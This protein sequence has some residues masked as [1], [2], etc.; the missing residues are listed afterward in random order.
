MAS[1]P[2]SNCWS[3][4]LTWLGV[5]AGLYLDTSWCGREGTGG[6]GP[7]QAEDRFVDLWREHSAAV[8]RYA[9]RR[10]PDAEVDEV[11][12]ETFL[13]AWRRLQDV[14]PFALPWLLAVARGVSANQRRS[15][16]RR[17]ALTRHLEAQPVSARPHL[18]SSSD[19]ADRVIVALRELHERDRELLTLVAWDGLSHEEAAEALGCS[20]ATFAVRLHRAR[21]R[22]KTA[23]EADPASTGEPRPAEQ[24][25]PVT[26]RS[27]VHSRPSE[28]ATR[29]R[30]DHA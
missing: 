4:R 29:G 3:A 6:G 28:P 17:E 16:G 2:R 11:V 25:A 5:I 8:V 26:P 19:R 14:P 9:R 20:R 21:R 15:M 10:V 27:T 18:W 1:G 24:V 22:L 30:G 7:V 12:A 13:V 23:L